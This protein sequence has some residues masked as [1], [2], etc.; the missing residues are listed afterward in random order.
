MTA[1]EISFLV[2]ISEARPIADDSVI[3]CFPFSNWALLIPDDA[4]TV[5]SAKSKSPGDIRFSAV[6]VLVC[7]SLFCAS[8]SQLRLSTRE[9]LSRKR[10]EKPES[11]N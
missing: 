6:F 8:L 4:F 11:R 5:A 10:D 2:A 1:L 3:G 9:V 7:F